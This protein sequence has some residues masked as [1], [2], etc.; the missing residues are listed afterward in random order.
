MR[1]TWKP[2]RPT[3]RPVRGTVLRTAPPYLETRRGRRDVLYR[4][5]SLESTGVLKEGTCRELARL[6]RQRRMET[7]G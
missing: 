6:K 4:C 1:S 7:T 3:S 5:G 2:A